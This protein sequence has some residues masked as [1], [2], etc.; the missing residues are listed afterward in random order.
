MTK[1]QRAAA[2]ASHLNTKA[3]L[4]TKEVARYMGVSM[5]FV[6]KLTHTNSI[7]YYKPSGKMCFFN[8]V[9]VENWMQQNR[10]ATAAELT[11]TANSIAKKG[12]VRC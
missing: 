2:D 5:S 1:I 9:E 11:D 10:C 4:T 8:R 7:P 3:V 6:Y 12:R